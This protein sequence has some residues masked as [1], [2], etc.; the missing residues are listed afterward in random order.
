MTEEVKALTAMTIL[1]KR[2]I[3]FSWESTSRSKASVDWPINA[4]TP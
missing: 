3:A 1:S 2:D 4:V